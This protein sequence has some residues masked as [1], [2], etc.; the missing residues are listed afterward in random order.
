[1]LLWTIN[2]FPA[3]GN[4]SSFSV[5][6]YKACLICDKETYYQYLKHSRK[7][8]YTGHMKFFPCNH[9]YRNWKNTFN[10]A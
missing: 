10:G 1:M 9:P 3:Y 6:G 7:L 5:K 4:L 2:D 8:C